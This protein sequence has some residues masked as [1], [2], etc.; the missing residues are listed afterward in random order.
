MKISRPWLHGTCWQMSFSRSSFAKRCQ[1]NLDLRQGGVAAR[2]YQTTYLESSL[3]RRSRIQTPSLYVSYGQPVRRSVRSVYC[4]MRGNADHDSRSHGIHA[5]YARDQRLKL[6]IRYR[7]HRL[8]ISQ[9]PA[10]AGN[11]SAVL[12]Q[13]IG[14]DGHLWPTISIPTQ[15]NID[16]EYRTALE[17]GVSMVDKACESRLANPLDEVQPRY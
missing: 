13:I 3:F 10:T 17:R 16:H 11:R 12:L 7:L 8:L 9:Q 14:F 5:V 1:T 6:E 15:A 4:L 2:Q